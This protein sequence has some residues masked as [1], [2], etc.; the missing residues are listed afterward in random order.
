MFVVVG[1]GSWGVVDCKCLGGGECVFRML[2]W[3][4][5]VGWGVV[6]VVG[7]CVG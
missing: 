1:V 3:I 5:I 7:G 2:R 6:V 4:G